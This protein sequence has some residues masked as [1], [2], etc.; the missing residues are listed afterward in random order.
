MPFP[1]KYIL[2]HKNTCAAILMA[3]FSTIFLWDS[4][5]LGQIPFMRDTF[6]ILMP[7]HEFVN[8]AIRDFSIPLWNPYTRFGQPF[9]ADPQNAVLYPLNALFLIFSQAF[10][11]KLFLSLHLFISSLGLFLLSR[12]WG[13]SWFPSLLTGISFSYSTFMIAQMETTVFPTCAWTPFVLL[14]IQSIINSH[15][16]ANTKAWKTRIIVL[17]PETVLLS[18]V[19]SLQFL[20]GYPQF[21]LYTLILSAILVSVHLFSRI[22]RPAIFSAAC[23][24]LISGSLALGIVMVQ[25]I[26]TWELLPYSVRNSNVNNLINTA[27]FPFS[28]LLSLLSPYFYG[29][30]G[31]PYEWLG[32][33]SLLEFWLSTCYIGIIPLIMISFLAL[34]RNLRQWGNYPSDNPTQKLPTILFFSLSVFIFGLVMASGKYTPAYEFF[35]NYAPFFNKF[36]WPSKFLFF[37][38]LGL[39]ILGG[40]GYHTLL[41]SIASRKIWRSRLPMLFLA[42]ILFAALL[43]SLMRLLP[44][45]PPLIQHFFPD[46]GTET[47]TLHMPR[48]LGDL[49]TA[50]AIILSSLFIVS[51]LCRLDSRHHYVINLIV[52]IFAFSNLALISWQIHFQAPDNIYSYRPPNASD[53]AFTNPNWRTHTQYFTKIK[54][55][56]NEHDLN[57][58][59]WTKEA[60]VL[61]TCLPFFHFRSGGGSIGVLNLQRSE[62]IFLLL[63]NEGLPD[64]KR[65]KL[66]NLL[67]IRYFI[68]GPSDK[69]VYFGN[70]PMKTILVE[71]PNWRPRAFIADLEMVHPSRNLDDALNLI[72]NSQSFDISLNATVEVSENEWLNH[73]PSKGKKKTSSPAGKMIAILYGWNR[74]D[75]KVEVTRQGLLVLNESWYK[76]WKVL[77][78]GK[79]KPVLIANGAFMGVIVEPG[80]QIISFEYAPLSFKTGSLISL[81]SIG[82]CC[83]LLA[84][85]LKARKSS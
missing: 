16:A 77:V 3:L 45:S 18:T 63:I 37:V 24:I 80:S 30:P 78:D 58:I 57:A 22:T 21:F 40:L 19:L 42:W 47:V 20:S 72:L 2:N 35:V 5:L 13:L 65:E 11:L 55:L 6:Y 27:S 10:A 29:W 67:S 59:L 44:H 31:Y 15:L 50:V 48:L 71:N 64:L 82:I 56:R 41:K 83:I 85:G 54:W 46:Y 73:C 62:Y 38:T 74:I 70:A 12:K 23:S 52:V 51:L 26:S 33:N 14:A 34:G 7:V 68:S 4:W 49:A 32:G 69:D 39:S 9:L 8:S 66:A 53:D 43:F 61:D 60:S 84:I 25:F 76:G 1:P 75:L 81:A 17:L 28:H 79:E 36:R